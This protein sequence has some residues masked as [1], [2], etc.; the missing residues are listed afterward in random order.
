M[1]NQEKYHDQCVE[2]IIFIQSYLQLLRLGIHC[3]TVPLIQWTLMFLFS[4]IILVVQQGAILGLLP[5]LLFT[6]L[7]IPVCCPNKHLVMVQINHIHQGVMYTDVLNSLLEENK[8]DKML[9]VLQFSK[10]WMKI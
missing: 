10:I 2:L 6:F 1:Q 4:N 8:K 5:P 9:V 7:H 3:L